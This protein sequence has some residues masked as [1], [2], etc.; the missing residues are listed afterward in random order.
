MDDWE[1]FNETPSPEKEDF[2]QSEYITDADHTHAK[3]VCKNFKMKDLG[4]IMIC[5]FKAIHY[6]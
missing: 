2:F 3:R 4:N 1:K 6:C 5:M